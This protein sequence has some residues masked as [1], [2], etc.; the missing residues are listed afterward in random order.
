LAFGSQ[1]ARYSADPTGAT[2]VTN[3]PGSVTTV[4]RVDGRAFDLFSLDFAGSLNSILPTALVVS[5]LT[6]QG[7]VSQ[8]SGRSSGMGLETININWTGLTS[9]SY[10]GFNGSTQQ[11]DN[12]VVGVDRKAKS[13]DVEM[14]AMAV[15]SAGA[16]PEPA[17][18]ALMLGGFG[19]I[20]FATR[21]RR[22]MAPILG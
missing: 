1:Y 21:R 22:A 18:W 10:Y 15:P 17:S 11:I 3:Y 19:A 16:V 14:S 2:L 12:L 5:F 8:L 7:P 6:S 20:G 9:F 13:S 4:S